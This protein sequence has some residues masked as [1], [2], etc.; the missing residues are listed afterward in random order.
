MSI[1]EISNRL[2]VAGVKHVVVS[3]FGNKTVEAP[4]GYDDRLEVF[5][6]NVE[7]LVEHYNKKSDFKLSL[8]SKLVVVSGSKYDKMYVIEPHGQR[9]IY[10]FI[11]RE[12]GDI[13]KPATA[14]APAKGARGNVFDADY[15]M[16]RMGPYGP[17][18]NK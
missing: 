6:K 7:D 1:H 12:N 18:Y 2:A 13:L 3:A 17:A 14:T 5:R 11:N 4:E 10:C 9:K 8:G 16:K 15:G